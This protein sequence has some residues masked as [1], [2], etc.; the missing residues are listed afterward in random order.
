MSRR[1]FLRSAA[2]YR[3]QLSAL[4]CNALQEDVGPGDVSATIFSPK[5]SGTARIVAKQPGVLSGSETV[6]EVFRQLSRSSK[7][8]WLIKD[9][10]HFREGAVLATINAPLPT[11]LTGERTALNFLQRLCGIATLSARFVAVL[12]KANP[13]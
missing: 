3:R 1:P 10:Q 12:Q 5:E 6:N 4:V 13:A 11:L 9:G 8:T 7:V 2:S